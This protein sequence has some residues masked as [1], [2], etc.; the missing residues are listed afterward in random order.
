MCGIL[1]FVGDNIDENLFSQAL[2]LINYRGPDNTGFYSKENIFL[3]HNRLSIIDLD[4][5]S[6]QP[7]TSSCGRYIIIYNGEIY[8][9]KEIKNELKSKGV[10]FRTSSD[11]EVILNS[12]IT[13][14][15]DCFLKLHGMFALAIYDI[16]EQTIILARDRMGEKPLF[17]F[18]EKNEFVFSSEMKSIKCIKND[19]TLD[20]EAMIDYLHFGYVPCP[21][22]IWKEIRK[23]E[24]GSY[25]K[26][27]INTRSIREKKYYYKVDLWSNISN[28]SVSQKSEQF[29]S[30]L[31]KVSEEIS[32]SDVPYGAFL[33]GGV[34]SSGAVAFL[35]Q[36]NPDL[37]A[38]TI[39]F[40]DKQFDETPYAE[41]VAK[42][43]NINHHV[44]KVNMGD[45]EQIYDKMVDLY[46]EPFNDF[47]FIPT[48]YVCKAAKEYGT[49]VISG[50][51]A[52][53]VFCGYNRYT[54]IQQFNRIKKYTFLRK[55]ISYAAKHLPL[56]SNARRQLIYLNSSENDLLYYILSMAFKDNEL[57][58][59]AGPELNSMLGKYSSQS[60]V[61][62]YLKDI[63]NDTSF[64]Q[65]M[66]YMDL[67]MT[68]PDD[69]LVKVDRASMYN[70]L[71]VRAFYLHPLIT[72]FAYTLKENELANEKTSKYF[73]KKAL[74]SYLPH[75]ILYRTKMGFTIPLK[76]WIFSELF[77]LLNIAL[78]NLPP[79]LFKRE[80]LNKIIEMQ[81]KNKRDF[82]LQI[83]SLMFL[84][85]WL[86]KNKVF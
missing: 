56:Y 1:G 47:S 34:D 62:N 67:K 26:Y 49:V 41:K 31:T 73:L 21:K 70:S 24:P 22:S 79:G 17:Y 16:S 86:K 8:N 55:G 39:G 75:D 74:E 30:I 59:I 78:D 3:G 60:V 48:Y 77:E 35:K 13:W 4:V 58:D 6:N 80:E 28:L 52:D 25:L 81:K 71:E 10:A 33:S 9:Y 29:K 40:D 65:K 53:E 50:D 63:P 38:F 72:D 44:K 11:T 46:D 15:E 18:N 57:H 23:L 27:S 37:R 36:H 45:V 20:N 32:V 7:F 2:S 54:K 76:K 85:R 83:H 43:L 12:Y 5:R 51:G 19:L 82:I 42:H 66:R 64:I 68:L 61:E 84:G 69:M 14:R